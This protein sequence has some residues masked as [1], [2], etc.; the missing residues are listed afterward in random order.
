MSL[1]IIMSAK[2]F[3]LTVYIN[4][5]CPGNEYYIKIEKE[6]YQIFFLYA[7]NVYFKY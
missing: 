2:G 4:V 5:F 1:E 3:F 6:H 7:D